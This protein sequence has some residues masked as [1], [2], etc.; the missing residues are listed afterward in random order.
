MIELCGNIVTFS[1]RMVYLAFDTARR[2]PFESIGEV[3]AARMSTR[4]SVAIA[5]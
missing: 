5:G 2:I 4:G 1:S 3:E